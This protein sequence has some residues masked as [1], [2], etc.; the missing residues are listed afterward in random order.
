MP[1]DGCFKNSYFKNILQ[2]FGT[3]VIGTLRSGEHF[4]EICMQHLANARDLLA[5]LLSLIHFLI[6]PLRCMGFLLFQ[7]CN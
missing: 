5:T 2:E 1:T 3:Y 6:M 4:F 7:I